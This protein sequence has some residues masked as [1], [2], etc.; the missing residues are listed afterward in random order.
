MTK[1]EHKPITLKPPVKKA[2]RPKGVLIGEDSGSSAE[3]LE[4][5]LPGV[6]SSAP[7][8][9]RRRVTRKATAKDSLQ[10]YSVALVGA[11]HVD[12]YDL[13]PGEKLAIVKLTPLAVKG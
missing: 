10:M 3:Q 12:G 9:K 13:K 1:K 2:A 5:P 7:E 11:M 8:Y 4:L 6:D